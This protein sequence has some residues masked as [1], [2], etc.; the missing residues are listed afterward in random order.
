MIRLVGWNAATK[1]IPRLTEDPARL[2]LWLC[3]L[4]WLV[5]VGGGGCGGWWW[6]LVVVG[7]GCGG[8]W[9]LLVVVG[10]C[11]GGCGGGGFRRP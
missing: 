6:L 11:C 4:W 9:L 1:E 2:W 10:G 3:W 8:G 5:V 7:G